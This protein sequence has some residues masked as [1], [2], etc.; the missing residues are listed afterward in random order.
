MY[1]YLNLLS[2]SNNAAMASQKLLRIV[3][4][5]TQTTQCLWNKWALKMEYCL[6]K[7]IAMLPTFFEI[8]REIR[9]W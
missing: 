8:S 3:Q 9:N 2:L 7:H 1:G 5:S 6:S 4:V